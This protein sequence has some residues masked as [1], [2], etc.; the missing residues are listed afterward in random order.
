MSV[1]S[2]EVDKPVFSYNVDW[3]SPEDPEKPINWPRWRKRGIIVAVCAMRFT[4][5]FASSTM[6]PA[7]LAIGKDF[8]GTSNTLLSFTVSIYIIGFGLGPLILAPLSEVYGRNVIYHVS[9]IMFT[10]FTACCGLSPNIGALLAFRVAAG[11][12]GGAPLTN[13]G[14][15]IADLVPAQE[16]GFIMS[17]FS[18]SMLIGPVLGPVV[19]GF[20]AQAK[21]W[22]WIFWAL[23][24][25][26]GCTTIV[27]FIF[28]RETYGPVLLERK[29][30]RLRKETGDSLYQ[31]E[32]K[33]AKSLRQLLLVAV[34]RPVRMLVNP[35]IL[36][37][38]LYMAVMYGI[39]YL[40]FTTF[41][42]VFQNEYGFKEGIA[43]LAY[44]GL[45]VGSALGMAIFGCY[46]DRINAQLAAKHGSAKPEYR[47]P[48]LIPSALAMPIGLVLYGWT[49]QYHLHW[50]VSIIG[51][52]FCGFSLMGCF[53]AI[54]TYLVD[55]FTIYASSA[56]AANSL[57]RSIA[58]GLV[59]LGGLGLY[60][61][62]GLGWGNT[63]LAFLS[64]LFG[65]SPVIF[66]KYG[67][68]LRQS[69]IGME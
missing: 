51:T 65:F 13:G 66:Y 60:D 30:A 45:G 1:S 23:T 37:T 28:L 43:G 32:G 41:S 10:L 26:S 2:V 33:S 5:P 8:P 22:R 3:N 34:T 19:G 24:I 11:F 56:L 44:L 68:Q 36:G 69:R 40:L 38:S 49:A 25:L 52:G 53:A 59:P 39:I 35:I 58:G 57:V 20:L 46:S 31:V 47:L 18:A 27:A 15:T 4:T 64:I 14:G 61:R 9:N 17:I 62:I 50:I 7:L 48:P 6:S 55:S 16:R 21:G 12:F 42:I 29:A 63:L 67:E 54:Q